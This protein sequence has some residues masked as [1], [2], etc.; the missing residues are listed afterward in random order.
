VGQS[1]SG[2][3]NVAHVKWEHALVDWL[4]AQQRGGVDTSYFWTLLQHHAP[5]LNACR[6]YAADTSDAATVYRT[7][8]MRWHE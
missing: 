8:V 5:P 7:R 6:F 4:Q 2:L 1:I 3:D